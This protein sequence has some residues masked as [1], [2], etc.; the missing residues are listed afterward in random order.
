MAEI[1][2]HGRDRV[3]FGAPKGKTLLVLGSTDDRGNPEAI[4]PVQ[5]VDAD[6]LATLKKSRVFNAL[7]ETGGI[8][9]HG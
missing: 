9:V 6:V 8:S 2:N 7:V 4:S 1:I 5:K 3:N